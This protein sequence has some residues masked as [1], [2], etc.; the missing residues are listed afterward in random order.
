MPTW[1]HRCKQSLALE[2]EFAKL[3]SDLGQVFVPSR[4]SVSPWAQ[5]SS[6]VRENPHRGLEPHLPLG[7]PG[8]GERLPAEPEVALPEGK[9]CGQ[10]GGLLLTLEQVAFSD[11]H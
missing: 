7:T 9:A 5:S 3:P 8:V 10:A 6:S 1:T 2:F 4:A 11:G